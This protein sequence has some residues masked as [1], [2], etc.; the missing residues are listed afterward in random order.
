MPTKQ[1]WRSDLEFATIFLNKGVAQPEFYEAFCE[2]EKERLPA[3]FE[4]KS[5]WYSRWEGCTVWIVEDPKE[6]SNDL[7]DVSNIFA[8]YL[9]WSR[10]NSMGQLTMILPLVTEEKV[11][12][13]DAAIHIKNEIFKEAKA[14]AQIQP[15]PRINVPAVPE[16]D[17]DKF[18]KE[19]MAAIQERHPK[20]RKT[21]LQRPSI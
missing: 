4:F 6:L 18:Q 9:L 8:A 12:S 17:L 2:A 1:T 5:A 21:M 15:N 19:E 16:T 7:L 14:L 20:V 11:S 13:L 10:L 3:I